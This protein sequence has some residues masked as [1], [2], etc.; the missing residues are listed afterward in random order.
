MVHSLRLTEA[1]VVRDL[2]V[3]GQGTGY[4]FPGW[5]SVDQ[6]VHGPGESGRPWSGSSRGEMVHGL[7][8]RVTQSM[9]RLGDREVSG[10]P[11]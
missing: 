11:W 1:Q 4:P 9:V 7:G 8:S 6:K 2:V 10:D 5:G 3:R